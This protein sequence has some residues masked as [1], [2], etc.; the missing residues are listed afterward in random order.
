MELVLLTLLDR[1][2]DKYLNLKN[3]YIFL[4]YLQDTGKNVRFLGTLMKYIFPRVSDV[5]IYHGLIAFINFT[6]NIINYKFFCNF[7]TIL[8]CNFI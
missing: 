3:I 1:F 7:L 6:L 8:Y 5:I 2:L 4:F